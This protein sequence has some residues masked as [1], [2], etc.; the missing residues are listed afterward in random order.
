M[1]LTWCAQRA[2]VTK[3]LQISDLESSLQRALLRVQPVRRTRTGSANSGTLDLEILASLRELSSPQTPD[4]LEELIEL[5][6]KDARVRLQKLALALEAR[7]WAALASTAHTLKGSANNLGARQLA[8][9]M[10]SLEK[11][12][13]AANVT[14]SADILLTVRSEFQEVERALLA[15]LQN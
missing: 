15:Q 1:P 3:P 10:A 5:F 14:D 7:D 11:Q 4:P 9:L 8:S 2:P 13:K 12:A 6:L